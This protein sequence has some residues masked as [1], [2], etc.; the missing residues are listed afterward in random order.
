MPGYCPRDR[1]AATRR[2][3][4]AAS[5]PT[6]PPPQHANRSPTDVPSR[7]PGAPRL[8]IVVPALDE[9]A[10]LP[11]LLADLSALTAPHEVVVAD[12]GS[13]DG[14]P[15]LAR[16][17]GARVVSAERGRGRQL[18]AGARAARGALLCFLHADARLD[19]RAVAALDALARGSD[20][21]GAWAF[22]LAIDAPERVFRLV[23]R[24]ANARSR[25]LAL[26]YGDQGLVV[27]RADYDAA[28]GYPP[29]PL[30]EDVALVR[31][32][33]RRGRVRLLDAAVTVSARRWRR[34]GVARRTLANWWLMLRFLA[35]AEPE[36][37]ARRY[38]PNEHRGGR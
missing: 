33:N 27:S 22:L 17:A 4:R 36:R 38:R 6:P 20:A 24:G 28:G 35:G 3:A 7:A 26:P 5:G 25:R 21:P 2:G 18:A 32:L 13:T 15:A 29:W 8:S 19:A 31:A 23:E 30:M 12:G 11:A 10:S 9:A 1:A 14:T 16:A 34:D 37:L